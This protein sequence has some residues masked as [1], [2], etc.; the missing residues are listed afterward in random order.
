VVFFLN[1]G[2]QSKKAKSWIMPFSKGMFPIFLLR[3][4]K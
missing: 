2:K 1:T 3:L 4:G